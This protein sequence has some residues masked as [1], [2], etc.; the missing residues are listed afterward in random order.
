MA[1]LLGSFDVSDYATWKETFDSDPLGRNAAAQGHRIFQDVDDPNHV[2]VGI[3]FASAEEAKAFRER[4]LGSDVISR[5]T[6]IQ[7]PTVVEVVDQAT[8]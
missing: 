1:S 7:M 3:E 8:Y 5:M 4:L 6:P 2:F